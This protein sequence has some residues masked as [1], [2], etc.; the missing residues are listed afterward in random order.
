MAHPAIDTH[1]ADA[2]VHGA[3]AAH[4][5]AEGA[6]SEVFPPLDST[7]YPS[8]LIWFAITFVALYWFVSTFILPNVSS[9]LEKRAAAKQSDLDAAAKSSAEAENA[10]TAMERAT[11]KA[12]AEARAMV[13]AARADVQAKLTAEQT[14]AEARLAERIETAEKRVNEA[15][16]NALADV[17]G[18]AD[19]LARDIATKLVPANG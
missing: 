8:Q 19:S 7:L 18:I 2:A 9:I 5:A 10:R 15:R 4:A 17:P 16:T 13:D 11:A 1:A 12:R 3:D 6:H 14:A